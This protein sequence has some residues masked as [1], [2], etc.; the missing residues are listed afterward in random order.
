MTAD[1]P[2]VIATF[3]RRMLL[4]L[5][6]GECVDARNK[7]KRLKP[8]VGDR[9]RAKPMDREQDWLIETIVDRRNALTRPARSHVDFGPCPQR[10]LR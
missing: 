3:S 5:P 9:V 4:Q 1:H 10:R 6:D 7:G 2:I 8:V